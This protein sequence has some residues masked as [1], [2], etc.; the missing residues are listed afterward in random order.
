MDLHGHGLRIVE[1]PISNFLP[2]EDSGYLKL[3]G[4]LE[5][6]QAEFAQL[7]RQ[8]CR[9]PAEPTTPCWTTSPRCCATRSLETPPNLGD[10]L[11][12]FL[13]AAAAGP[14]CSRACALAPQ[15]DLLDAL[16][17]ERR[18]TLLDDWFESDAGQG[19]VRLRR[20]RRQLRQPLHA[21]LGLRAAA[22]LLRRG[23]RQEGRLGPRHRRHG[24]HHA[25]HGA[26][27]RSAG[28]QIELDAPVQRGAGREAAAPSASA[29]R[30]AR[31]CAPASSRPTS[32]RALLFGKLVD[33]AA[34]PADFREAHRQA[35]AA[36][37]ARFRMNVALVGAAGLH[38]LPGKRGG[39][40]P[41]L[42][43]RH[44]AVARLHGP[45]LSRRAAAGMSQRAHRR[46]ADSLARWTTASR[47]PGQHVASLFCQ[48]FA[49]QLPDGRSW[50]DDREEAGR[51]DDRH[52][53]EVRPQLQALGARPADHSARS[54][55]SA[56]SAW[57]A[58]TSST[59]RWRWTSSGRRGRCSATPAIARRSGACTCAGRAR[60]P[61]AASP[62]IP[63]TMPRAR[64]CGTSS[65]GTAVRLSLGGN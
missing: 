19:R 29:G 37:P 23:E 38:C 33:P 22:P 54:T 21:R 59:A 65:L 62:A 27:L 2:L 3:G 18:A 6:T 47:P 4:G 41:Q 25:G 45:G 35:T 8:G 13:R 16:H 24:R 17:A 31:C 58:A 7:L 15:R 1:R 46:D 48:Q 10:G 9:A 60:T 57:S 42:R 12:G 50:D 43:H 63:G 32:T 49:P 11:P 28:V 39:R 56:P 20:R 40:A 53:D 52:G 5:R 30:R 55:S 64:S 36:A 51:P 61:A 34:L 14:A 26:G 44:R